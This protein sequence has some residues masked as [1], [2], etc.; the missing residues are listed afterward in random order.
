MPEIPNCYLFYN[1][2]KKKERPFTNLLQ[3]KGKTYHR[4]LILS[5]VNCSKKQTDFW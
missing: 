2:Y 5:I 4:Y 3:R 1:K